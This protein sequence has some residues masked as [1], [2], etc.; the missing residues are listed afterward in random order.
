MLDDMDCTQARQQGDVSGA[1]DANEVQQNANIRFN[2]A[3][4]S[5]GRSLR[6]MV[7]AGATFSRFDGN[8]RV[9]GFAALRIE[10]TVDEDIALGISAIGSTASNRIGGFED[11]QVADVGANLQLYGRARLD[12]QLIGGA[13]VGI[14]HSWYDFDLREGGLAI[15]GNFAGDR[16]LAGALLR[17][18][19]ELGGRPATVDF[20]ISHASESLGTASFDAAFEDETANGVELLLGNVSWTRISLPITYSPFGP[21]NAEEGTG[22]DTAVGLLC[23]DLILANGIGCGVQVGSRL[24]HRDENGDLLFIDADFERVSDI[25][26]LRVHAGYSFEIGLGPDIRMDA[27]MGAAPG[28]EARADLTGMLS[29]RVGY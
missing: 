29:L 16:I 26:R 9:R 19:F 15:D 7:D 3:L 5:C 24:W 1:I 13:F 28:G 21:E 23:E 17:G 18:E 11:S 8:S 4:S 27:G 10:K 25:T 22:L 20:A 6:A 14:G 12:E 2:D